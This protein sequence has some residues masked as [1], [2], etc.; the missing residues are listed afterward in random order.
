MSEDQEL[1]QDEIFVT[2]QIGQVP[3]LVTTRFTVED[4]GNANPRYIRSTMYSVP[5]SLDMVKQVNAC[6][7][8]KMG[9]FV[10]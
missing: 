1:H 2:N 3:P 8:C 4:E 5:C 10:A 7:T 6:F 9:L